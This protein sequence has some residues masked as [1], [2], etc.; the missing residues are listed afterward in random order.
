[1]KHFTGRNR[2]TPMPASEKDRRTLAESRSIIRR[3]K[4]LGL[5]YDEWYRRIMQCLPQ[6]RGA[7]LEIGSGGGFLGE[8]LP[9]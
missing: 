2:E 7:V 6:T 9:C 1:M 8:K 3:K 5:I 4:F